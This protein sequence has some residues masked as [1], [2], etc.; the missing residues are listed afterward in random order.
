MSEACLG[1]VFGRERVPGIHFGIIDSPGAERLSAISATPNQ[2]LRACPNGGMPESSLRRTDEAQRVP[3]ISREV[4]PSACVDISVLCGSA[5]D[6]HHLAAPDSGVS[7]AR[8][9][10]VRNGNRHPNASIG[11]VNRSCLHRHF[12]DIHPAPHNKLRACP[13]GTMKQRA[14]RCLPR[15]KRFPCVGF[16]RVTATAIEVPCL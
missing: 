2:H 1:R 10:R 6:E 14:F 8:T 15:C 16:P 11:C 4:I 13:N 7:T 9:R 3:C 12:G 5:P